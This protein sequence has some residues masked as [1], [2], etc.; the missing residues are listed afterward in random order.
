M[1]VRESHGLEV[2]AHLPGE[3]HSLS[4]VEAERVRSQILDAAVCRA[5]ASPLDLPLEVPEGLEAF[6]HRLSQL[7][8]RVQRLVDR[9]DKPAE[10]PLSPLP[11][12][13][14]P[15]G[16]SPLSSEFTPALREGDWVEIKLV[17]PPGHDDPLWILGQAVR[18]A[19]GPAVAFRCVAQDQADHL[20]RYLL[21]RQRLDQTQPPFTGAS[22]R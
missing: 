13:L 19:A 9:L 1:S 10:K 3:I 18:E 14:R 17:L 11:V 12:R 22:D 5:Q 15:D 2:V 20:V 6:A 21:H 7:E 4:S 8:E 16:F